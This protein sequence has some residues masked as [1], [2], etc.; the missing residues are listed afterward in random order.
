MVLQTLPSISILL[1]NSSTISNP[2]TDK[3]CKSEGGVSASLPA[4]GVAVGVHTTQPQ[5]HKLQQVC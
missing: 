5:T 2:F 3:A 4:Q 1:I